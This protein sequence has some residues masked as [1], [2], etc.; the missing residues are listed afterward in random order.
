M[1]AEPN[2]YIGMLSGTSRDGA[3][4]VLVR[5]RDEKPEILTAQCISYPAELADTLRRMIERRQRPANEELAA[6][7]Q[8]LSEFFAMAAWGLLEEA[9]VEAS[10][11]TAIGSHGQTVWHK[12]AAP[13]PET[14]QLGNPARIARLLG[15][16]TIGH[17]RQADVAAGGQGAP[18]A[19]LLHRALLK[20]AHGIRA[21]LNIGGIANLSLIDAN[22]HVTGYDTGPGNCLLDTW[23]RKHRGSDYDHQGQ[24]AAGGQVDRL[25]LDIL[26]ADPYFTLPPPKST[27]VEYFNY[28]W[29]QDRLEQR[30]SGP[31]HADFESTI[32]D[33]QATLSEF[34][35]HTIAEALLP[36]PVEELLVCGGGTHNLDLMSRLRRLLPGLVVES[37]AS[38]GIDPDWMEA[39]LFAWLAREH[40]AGRK[41]DT[42][43]ITGANQPVLLGEAFH[44]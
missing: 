2:L 6:V 29:L 43:P 17:F 30:L 7:D 8:E 28:H 37:T 34:T 25:L 14:I 16:T 32:Q 35:A 24:W 40:L 3:D 10:A 21:V 13:D 22:G 12:P 9:G 44:P 33:V 11:V 26:L 20:P 38:K 27:G 36:T 4:T 23:V 15:I 31:A 42:G 19:P 41:Q 18:L 39:I 5:F 1:S